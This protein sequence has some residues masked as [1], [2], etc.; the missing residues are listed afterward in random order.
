[1][2]GNDFF[3]D[4]NNTSDENNHSS[5]EPENSGLG[6][7][8]QSNDSKEVTT[9]YEESSVSDLILD[10]E[11]NS[12]SHNIQDYNESTSPSPSQSS[13]QSAYPYLTESV[14]KKKGFDKSFKKFIAAILIISLVG[15][16]LFGFFVGA[17]KSF[18]D[19]MLGKTQEAKEEVSEAEPFSFDKIK[20][21]NNSNSSAK[22][23]SYVDVISAVEPSVVSISTTFV[24]D[25]DNYYNYYYFPNR[26][27]QE[28]PGSGSGIIFYEDSTKVYIATNYHVI[29]D[30]TC[31][32]SITENEQIPASY[33]GG[34][35]SSDLAVIS[36]LKEDL[37]KEGINSVTVAKLG[38]SDSLKVGEPCIAIGNAMGNGKTA[39]SGM[40]SA[41][42]RKLNIDG[43]NYQFIQTDAAI[44]PGNSGGALINASG[45]VIGINTAK[46]SQSSVEGIGFAIPSNFAKPIIERIINTGSRPFLGITGATV[47]RDIAAQFGFPIASGV[48]VDS[49]SEG[50]GAKL[51]GVIPG[52][53]ITQVDG[54]TILT[55]EDLQDLI[56]TKKLGDVVEVRLLRNAKETVDLK[57]T[58]VEFNKKGN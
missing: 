37:K 40:I 1:M 20:T 17:G 46:I 39:T 5:I 43:V 19:S 29:G 35:E 42:S 52:D 3:N 7:E 25:Y 57:I 13:S 54:K 50:G 2:N 32:V 18:T 26:Y 10:E 55:M 16:P 41:L 33:V 4:N 11:V 36:V 21:I 44:N 56:A 22:L 51:A 27:Q 49:V 38:D 53:I 47:T 8:L 14:N 15:A 30:T 23:V 9:N 45:E 6:L 12:T 48:F 28:R 24:Q 34:D 31:Y 58:L